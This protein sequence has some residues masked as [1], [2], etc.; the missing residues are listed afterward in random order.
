MVK[1]A[2]G[3]A[4]AVLLMRGGG[5]ID[6]VKRASCAAENASEFRQVRSKPI[7]REPSR[8][9]RLARRTL[10]ITSWILVD[11]SLISL[12]IMIYTRPCYPINPT[13]T[14]TKRNHFETLGSLHFSMKVCGLIVSIVKDPAFSPPNCNFSWALRSL[15]PIIHTLRSHMQ[16]EAARNI[17][18]EKI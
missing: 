18:P 6:G 15:S 4:A 7:K 3:G 10:S 17:D 5:G 9:T 12:Y 11:M 1:I 8:L 14:N 13:Y 2:K 16:T